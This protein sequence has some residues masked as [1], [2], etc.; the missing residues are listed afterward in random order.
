MPAITKLQIGVI[1]GS[2]VL[3]VLLFFAPRGT[4]S[5][6][7]KEENQKATAE[8]ISVNAEIDSAIALVNGAAPM[9]GILMLREIAEENPDNARAQFQLGVFSMQSG[10]YPKALERFKTVLEIDSNFAEAKLFMGHAHASLGDTTEAI[11]NFELFQT[12]VQDEKVR[13]EVERYIKELTK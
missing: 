10:Q 9:K 13:E 7:T 8:K 3:G 2:V 11:K 4:M 6:A 5:S 1:S 12:S